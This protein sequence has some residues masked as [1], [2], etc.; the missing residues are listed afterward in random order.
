MRIKLVTMDNLSLN[1]PPT[2]NYVFK[3]T[4]KKFNHLNHTFFCPIC[5]FVIPKL[6]NGDLVN[7]IPF[8]LLFAIQW[9]WN[10]I[11]KKKKSRKML[12]ISMLS[13]VCVCVCT[14]FT[15]DPN[16]AFRSFICILENAFVSPMM[17]LP[18]LFWKFS[19]FFCWCCLKSEHFCGQFRN[20]KHFR[21]IWNWYTV[22]FGQDAWCLSDCITA[23]HRIKMHVFAIWI[24]DGNSI[25]SPACKFVT[26]L[27][28]EKIT[29]STFNVESGKLIL[30]LYL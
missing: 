22:T 14:T 4:N 30:L 16:P 24:W 18:F 7:S 25:N 29:I 8:A 19:V 23:K 21:S 2:S 26:I 9:V 5:I 1:G 6:Y 17:Q 13:C 11:H 10:F 12:Y 28:L 15:T 20:F 3:Q 27:N